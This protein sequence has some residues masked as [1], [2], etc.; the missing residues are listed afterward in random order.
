MHRSQITIDAGAVKSN[1]ETLVR[2]LE[3]TELWAVVKADGYGHGAIDVGRAALAAGARAL[4][5]ATVPEALVLREAIGP[6][7]LVVMGPCSA[8]ELEQA[9]EARLELV[10]ATGEVPEGLP[11]HLKLDTGMARWGLSE[12]PSPS[13][14]VV[15][16]MTHLATADSD[17]DLA[18]RQLQRFL[19]ATQNLHGLTRHAA[20]SAAAI[21]L[22]SSRLEA[23]RCGIAIYGLS[24][25]GDDPASHGLQPALR[26]QS[27]LAQIG[28][29][30]V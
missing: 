11:L 1:V 19:A 23:V 2:L 8:A 17:L 21:R 13:R 7:R 15:G 14:D 3:G 27:H 26:W 29:A 12:L 20:N 4:C 18:E 10:V 16:L 28:R 9:R 25:F 24:P 6:A 5:V 30:H 22:P